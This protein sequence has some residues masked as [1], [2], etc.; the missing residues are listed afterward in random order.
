MVLRTAVDTQNIKMFPTICTYT[1][2][3]Q[4]NIM[5]IQK[6]DYLYDY[7]NKKKFKCQSS[8]KKIRSCC[9]L[10]GSANVRPANAWFKVE[11]CVARQK[12]ISCQTSKLKT[13]TRSSESQICSGWN[14]REARHYLC[15]TTSFTMHSRFNPKISIL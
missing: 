10:S 1:S 6:C 2:S 14:L 8:I 12:F 3:S 15:A 7:Y 11:K 13:Q 9:L 5:N 4:E